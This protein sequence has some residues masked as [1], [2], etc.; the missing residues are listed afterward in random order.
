[1]RFTLF[2]VLLAAALPARSVRLLCV[3]APEDAPSALHLIIGKE[4]TRLDLPRLAVST[5]KATLPAT[6]QRARFSEHAPSR[7]HHLPADAPWVDIP[8]GEGDVLL[9]LLPSNQPG[10]LGFRAQA[11]D[12]SPTRLPDGSSLWINLTQ[13]TLEIQLG[14]G[15]ARVLPGQSRSMAPGVA[16]GLAYPVLVDLA[17]MAGEGEPTPLVRATWL[18]E[19]GRRQLLFVLNDPDRPMPRVLSIPDWLKPPEPTKS[20]A[21]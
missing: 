1:M 8:A 5:G 17:A 9:I 12:F 13:R 3:D 16:S 14:K 21:R 4:A 19:P 10:P 15:K 2:L 7:E 20:G 18:R 6:A 11:V